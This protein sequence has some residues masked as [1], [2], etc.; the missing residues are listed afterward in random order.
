MVIT[1]C[2]TLLGIVFCLLDGNLA[3]TQWALFSLILILQR[4]KEDW[5]C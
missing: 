1:L 2:A 3:A 5:N 4:F